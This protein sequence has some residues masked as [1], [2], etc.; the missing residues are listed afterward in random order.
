MTRR[1]L[2]R[3][4][5]LSG[6]EAARVRHAELHSPVAAGS[7]ALTW[8]L[9]LL[10]ATGAALAESRAASPDLPVPLEGVAQLH[11]DLVGLR[12]AGDWATGPDPQPSGP[13][14]Y[15]A[16]VRPLPPPD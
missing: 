4:A 3:I 12:Q 5:A 9:T 15:R 11:L 10:D 14:R 2:P 13:P 1:R 8:T 16:P 7:G 6:A